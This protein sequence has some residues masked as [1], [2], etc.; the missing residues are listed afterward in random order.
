MRRGSFLI[1][2]NFGRQTQT[3]TERR[4][5]M[6]NRQKREKEGREVGTDIWQDFGKGEMVQETEKGNEMRIETR[7]GR[8]EVISNT[9]T[10]RFSG[11]PLTCHNNERYVQRNLN[12]NNA[13]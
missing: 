13:H 2:R 1:G 6:E 8:K 5:D 4:S 11:K 12:T 10:R 9:F 3:E 7:K